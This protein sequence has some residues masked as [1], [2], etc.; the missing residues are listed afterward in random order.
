MTLFEHSQL[1]VPQIL[2]LA[3]AFILKH[4]VGQ[5]STE[6]GISRQY[7]SDWYSI[8]RKV[9]TEQVLEETQGKQIG[10]LNPDGTRR[11]VEIDESH[12]TTRKFH[13]GRI[14]KGEQYWVLAANVGKPGKAFLYVCQIGAQEP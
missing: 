1:T 8:F 2:A 10:G 4:R 6:T 11:V 7:V 13:E 9:C 12:I 3:Y 14:L 5:A